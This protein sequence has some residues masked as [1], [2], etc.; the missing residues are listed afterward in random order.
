MW[1]LEQGTWHPGNLGWNQETYLHPVLQAGGL[2]A[3]GVRVLLPVHCGG[4]VEGW[5]QGG[6]AG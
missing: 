2:G 6:R 4:T 3:E 1:G 5:G